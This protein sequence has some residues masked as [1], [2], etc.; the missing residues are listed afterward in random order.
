[1][2]R[3]ALDVMPVVCLVLPCLSS[4]G[5]SGPCCIPYSVLICSMSFGLALFVDVM[6]NPLNLAMLQGVKSTAR[7]RRRVVRLSLPTSS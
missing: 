1:V 6:S 2:L 3:R 4:S 5:A 7:T